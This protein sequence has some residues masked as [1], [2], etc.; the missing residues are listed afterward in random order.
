MLQV[1]TRFPQQ[2]RAALQPAAKA[3]SSGA[4]GACPGSSTT[5]TRPGR[6]REDFLHHVP[7]YV[8]E[9][10]VPP[11]ALVRQ[12]RVLHATAGGHRGGTFVVRSGGLGGDIDHFVCAA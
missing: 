6:S 4:A 1:K 11:L 7:V 3:S 12:P 5:L 2:Y 8:G 10:E 9:S